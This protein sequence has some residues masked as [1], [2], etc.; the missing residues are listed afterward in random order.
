LESRRESLAICATEPVG[1]SNFSFD[2]ADTTRGAVGLSFR[3]NYTLGTT[4]I[5]PSATV[6]YW[7]VFDG[8]YTSAID[9]VAFSYDGTGQYLEASATLEFADPNSGWS[10]FVSGSG[11]LGGERSGARAQLGVNIEW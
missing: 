7:N 11:F 3:G 4:N 8:G 5:I 1:G 2:N 10:G 9:A 6:K